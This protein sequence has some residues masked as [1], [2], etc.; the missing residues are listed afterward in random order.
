VPSGPRTG[1]GTL[2]VTPASLSAGQLALASGALPRADAGGTAR[3]QVQAGLS[4]STVAR[5]PI[6]PTGTFAIAWRP[7]R[8]GELTLR[9]ITGGRAQKTASAAVSPPSATSD[10]TLS[11]Y[12]QVVVTWYGPGLYGR[13]TACGQKLSRSIVGVAHRTLPC[14]TPISLSHNGRTLVL[15]V[16]DRGPF[17]TGATLDLT[18][19]AA[20]ELGITQTTSIGMIVLGGP[21]LSPTNWYPPGGPRSGAT[22]TTGANP[23]ST[24]AGGATAPS[25]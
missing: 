11:V 5:G 18:H 7:L 4:W 14:G 1:T 9:A 20:A 12:R 25:G 19:A 16:I 2:V 13:H 21:P 3:L 8:S 6:G 22:G 23:P 24:Y 17:G 15:P 10:A